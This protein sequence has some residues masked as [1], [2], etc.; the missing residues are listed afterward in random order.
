MQKELNTINNDITSAVDLIL[1]DPN[2]PV[3]IKTDASLKGLGAV[4]IQDG[5]P[6][7]FLS[8]TLTPVEPNYTKIEREL[9]AILFAC[10]KLCRYTFVR[11]NHRGHRSQ[12]PAGHLSE[13]S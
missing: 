3:I 6:V 10:E 4:L 13:P 11:K 12:A 2:K 9:L 5:K 8:K 7:R 1:H